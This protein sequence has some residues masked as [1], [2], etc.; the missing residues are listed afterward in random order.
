MSKLYIT[1][2]NIGS[3]KSTWA[4]KMA[5]KDPKVKIVSP[6]AIRQML[7]G[8]YKYIEG[9]DTVIT[10][11]CC[12]AIRDLIL[13]G[14]D[15]I[16]DCCNYTASRRLR[17]ELVAHSMDTTVQCLIFPRKDMEWHVNNRKKEPHADG[18][19][20]EQIWKNNEASYEPVGSVPMTT[21]IAIG[22]D[23]N[24]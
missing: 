7:N 15:V 23:S 4:R 11:I 21:G 20:W 12:Q 6:D 5:E 19:D 16:V 17:W 8:T 18:T 10:D 22:E 2:G 24:V 13:A 1:V 14:Y 9:L 3:G